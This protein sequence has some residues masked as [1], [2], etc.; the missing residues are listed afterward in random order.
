MIL[1]APS[2][3][4]LFWSSVEALEVKQLPPLQGRRLSTAPTQ[5]L[6]KEG[7]LVEIIDISNDDEGINWDLLRRE[8]EPASMGPAVK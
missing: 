1:T 7:V 3:A 6:A 4:R 8:S 5:P 2:G